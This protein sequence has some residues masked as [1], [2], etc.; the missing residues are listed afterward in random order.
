M[1]ILIENGVATGN[2]LL[3]S[4]FIQLFPNVSFPRYLTPSD[5]EPF[6][7]GCY[8]FSSVP[9]A[10]RYTKF[11]EV[12]AVRDEEGIWR[13]TWEE[14]DMSDEEKAVVDFDQE[15]LIRHE[16]NQLLSESD[17]TQFNDSPLEASDKSSWAVY[18]QL[19][20]DVPSQGGFPWDISWPELPV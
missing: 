13:Q 8:E 7:Y 11:V 10:S 3:E 19:L 14:T 20:R 12:P 6:G 2:P 15:K 18:R 17:W 1:I 5:V 4:N 9:E 16:R